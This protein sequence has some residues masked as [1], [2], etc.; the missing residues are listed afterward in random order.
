MKSERKNKSLTFIKVL[1]FLVFSPAIVLWDIFHEKP[2]L[3]D[4][5]EWNEIKRNIKEFHD[6]YFWKLIIT[7]LLIYTCLLLYQTK[8]GDI[9]IPVVMV[10]R[11]KATGKDLAVAK[12]EVS[13]KRNLIIL[14]LSANNGR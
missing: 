12:G 2:S 1:L 8:T 6:R 9:P 4:V 11:D 7:G 14:Q 5:V 13:L 3:Q 10:V